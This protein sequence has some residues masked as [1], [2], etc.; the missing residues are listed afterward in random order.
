MKNI[1]KNFEKQQKIKKCMNYLNRDEFLELI[2][3]LNLKIGCEIGVYKADYSLKILE[4]TNLSKLYLI[5][6]WQHLSNYKDISNHD[7]TE[8]DLIY[9]EVKNKTKKFGE[10]VEIIKDLSENVV[11]KF[12]DNY[13]DFLYLDADHSY[14]ASKKDVAIWWSKVKPG[15][16]FSGHD[17]LNGSLPQGEFGV[18]RSVD[19]FVAKNNLTLNITGE[20]QWKSWFIIKPK[21]DKIDVVMYCTENYYETSINLI[22]TLNIFHNNFN[23]YLYEV[24]FNIN[25]NIENVTII[26]VSDE[27][28]GKIVFNQNR[29]DFTNKD[30]FR[31]IFLK[32]K[33]ILHSLTELKLD[34]VLYLDS[35]LLPTNN[36]DFILKYFKEIE[37]YPLIQEGPAEFLMIDGRGNPFTENGYDPT[38]ILEYPIMSMLGIPIENRIKYANASVVLYN[39]NCLEF[40]K[41]YD[42]LNDTTFNFSLEEIKYYYPF[43]DETT[44]NILLWKYKY[45]KRMPFLQVNIDN[46]DQVK[47]FYYSKYETEKV[48]S[49]FTKIPSKYEKMNKPFFHGVKNNISKQTSDFIKNFYL[50]NDNFNIRVDK[51]DNKTYIQCNNTLDVIVTL[52]DWNSLD[53]SLREIYKTPAYFINNEMWFSSNNQ[54]N[55]LKGLKV[56]IEYYGKIIK[57][58]YIDFRNTNKPLLVLHSEVGI[59]DNL[60]ATPTIK[61]VSEIYNQKIILLTYI[62]QA[63]INNPYVENIIKLDRNVPEHWRKI[64]DTLDNS[65]NIYHL[66]NLMGTNWRLVDHKQICAL[67]CGFQLKPHELDMEFYPDPYEPIEN[68]PEKFI[69]INPSETEPERTWGSENWQKFIDLIQEHI[70]VVAIGKTS[71]LDPNLTKKFSYINIKNGL[72]LMDHPSQNT[73]SQAYHIIDKSK[74]FVTMNNGLY[75]LSLCNLNN[76]ITELATAWE[77]YYYRYRKGIENYNLDYI[78]GS[79]N[80]ECLSNPKICLEQVGSL[81]ILKSGICYLNKNTYECHPTPEQVYESVLKIIK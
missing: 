10:R 81:N 3:K 38:K 6:P 39:K 29:N 17:Y 26:K 14:E 5:D 49:T 41:E 9:E 74:T 15:G 63:F 66:F 58:K 1:I 31:A 30:M 32:S 52:Y 18:K 16:I 24:N 11:N 56:E 62:P 27:R 55:S 36:I 71:Y 43:A 73:L 34:E 77:T 79:C 28:I 44:I 7:N 33:V 23:I 60:A 19:E 22:K 20:D 72:N 57:E 61:K 13:F 42:D 69:C 25:P 45:N 40:I 35:D 67:N 76:H 68:L 64:L 12:E 8:F 78:R 46:I 65:Y 37:N 48:Y 21:R 54:L 47:E 75:I 53:N 2:D 51:N 70:P 59:G 4:K 50:D 80:A